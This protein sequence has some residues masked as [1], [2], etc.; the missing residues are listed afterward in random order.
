MKYL[1]EFTKRVGAKREYSDD[2]SSDMEASHNEIE[3]EEKRAGKIAKKED[4][5]EL[6]RI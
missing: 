5:R 6:L 1:R 4:A 3:L 2:G